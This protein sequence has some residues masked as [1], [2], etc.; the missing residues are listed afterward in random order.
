ME[1]VT[2]KDKEMAMPPKGEKLSDQ[3]IEILKQWV[4]SGALWPG[5]MDQID[6]NEIQLWSFKPIQRKEVPSRNFSDPN[7][8]PIDF[9]FRVKQ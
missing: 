1:V 3:N 6:D 7:S 8:Y 4:N 2:H 9:F 5:Q